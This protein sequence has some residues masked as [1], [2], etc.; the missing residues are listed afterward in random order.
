MIAYTCTCSL[1]ARIVGWLTACLLV[2]CFFLNTA[3][4]QSPQQQKLD[5]FDRDMKQMFRE[6]MREQADADLLP[7]SDPRMRKL[8][9][10]QF[11][12]FQRR[13][14][15]RFFGPAEPFA[16]LAE[17]PF[18]SIRNR[19][20]GLHEKQH[21]KHLEIYRPVV[22]TARLST[23]A[24]RFT[25][26]GIAGSRAATLIQAHTRRRITQLHNLPVMEALRRRRAV[27]KIQARQRGRAARTGRQRGRVFASVRHAS[28]K[29][30]NRLEKLTGVDLD[31]DG[32]VG[33][34][35]HALNAQS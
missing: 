10:E 23:V 9:P 28:A 20:V 19:R 7:P 21:E 1:P 27:V 11:D 3:P 17:H 29:A 30:I 12:E 24:G 6:L 5:Q 18:E 32:D 33:V 13:F 25:F 15:E 14:F 22:K 4:A 34:D 2:A 16:D 31:R 8:T 35:G 26:R